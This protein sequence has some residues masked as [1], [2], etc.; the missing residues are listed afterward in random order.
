MIWQERISKEGIPDEKISNSMD[1]VNPI[2]IPRNH[3]VE[4]ALQAAVEENNMEPFKKLFS[5]M[6]NPYKEISGM[7][8]YANPIKGSDSSYKTFCGT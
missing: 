4:T 1:A 8:E 5:V 6:Q 2:Y 7:E 3:N